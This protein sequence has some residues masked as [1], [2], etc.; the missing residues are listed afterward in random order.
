[1]TVH[2]G[3]IAPQEFIEKLTGQKIHPD[4]FFVEPT[5]HLLHA[6]VDPVPKGWKGLKIPEDFRNRVMMGLGYVFAVGPLVGSLGAA[7]PGGCH[8]ES[9]EDLLGLHVIFSSNAGV[10]LRDEVAG[11]EYAK[12]VVMPDRDIRG[13]DWN[14]KTQLERAREREQLIERVH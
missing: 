14:P 1:M 11:V 8:C 3:H 13:V 5:G 10:F 2:R 6:V 12:V 9:P 7:Y 4:F